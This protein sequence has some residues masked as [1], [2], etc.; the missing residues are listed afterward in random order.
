[1]VQENIVTELGER[2]RAIKLMSAELTHQDGRLLGFRYELFHDRS[3]PIASV[4]Q[5]MG[6]ELHRD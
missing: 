5:G 6:V 4:W 1:M 3:Y 2:R